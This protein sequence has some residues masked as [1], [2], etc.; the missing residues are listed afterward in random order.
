VCAGSGKGAGGTAEAGA[1]RPV[2]W[3]ALAML[4][5]E[6]AAFVARTEE[7]YP[8]SANT[9][10][11]AE[12]RAAY[13]RMCAAF[14]APYPPGVAA[15]EEWLEAG[16]RRRRLAIRRYRCAAPRSDAVLLY[17]HGGGFVLG[18]LHSHDDVCADLCDAAGIEVV[19]IDY[20]LAPEHPYPAAL[21]DTE[22]AYRSLLREGRA[23][24]VGGDSAGGSLDL[25]GR[26]GSALRRRSQV[27]RPAQARRCRHG[28]ARRGGA[29]SRISAGS[30]LV[31][32]GRR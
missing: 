24:V 19:A 23:I 22:A 15:A 9:A 3:A 25:R 7:Y 32:E 1:G 17:L 11:V 4:D 16:P 26:G 2:G 13:D 8:A 27:C 31:R 5:P 28:V 12:N 6:I 21:D 29:G 20:R 30:P 10:P 18:G 14:C